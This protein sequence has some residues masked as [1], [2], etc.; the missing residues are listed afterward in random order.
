MARSAVQRVI[1]RITKQAVIANIAQEA[2]IARATIDRIIALARIDNIIARARV[3]RIVQPIRA[4]DLIAL[5]IGIAR[6]HIVRTRRAIDH[7]RRIA[8][9]R[10][11]LG[12]GDRDRLARGIGIGGRA[13]LIVATT[14]GDDHAREAAQIQNIARIAIGRIVR[15]AARAIRAAINRDRRCARQNR[16]DREHIIARAAIGII[17]RANGDIVIARAAGQNIIALTAR[18]RIRPI[19]AVQRVNARAT[20]QAIIACTACNAVIARAAV[21]GIIAVACVDHIITSLDGRVVRGRDC[22]LRGRHHRNTVVVVGRRN[23]HAI[24]IGQIFR[25][26][27]FSIWIK[28]IINQTIGASVQADNARV[29]I[30]HDTGIFQ[31]GL[32]ATHNQRAA[33]ARRDEHQRADIAYVIFNLANQGQ[34]IAA[35]ANGICIHAEDAD[36]VI[37]ATN[38]HIGL[39]ADFGKNGRSAV[40]QARCRSNR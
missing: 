4:I 15:I 1:A 39:A 29:G 22:G 19:T 12:E 32:L 8:Q 2:V 18:K 7:A 10:L 17:A 6:R 30:N 26:I 23:Q 3:D 20:D 21:N 11:N 27:E 9:D 38:K 14:K 5:R 37:I 35:I 31:F 28:R 33:I 13:C 40:V 36:I 25:V 24:D 34:I 16:S